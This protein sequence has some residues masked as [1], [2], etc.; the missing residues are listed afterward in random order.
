MLYRA[1]IFTTILGI[2]FSACGSGSRQPAADTSALLATDSAHSNIHPAGSYQGTLPCADCPGIDYQISLYDDNHYRTLMVYRD[3]NN[4]RPVI[5]TGTWQMEQD[6]LVRIIL[7]G[8]HKQLFRFEDGR[9]YQLNE[10][11]QPITGALADNYILRPVKSIDRGRLQE[12]AAAGIDF[13]A[14]GTR[15]GWNLEIDH[16]KTIS[17]HITNGDSLR[18]PMPRA[19]PNTDTLKVYTAKTET[20]E[21]ILTI[22]NAACMDDASGFMHPYSVEVQ[23]KDSTYRGCGEYL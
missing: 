6:T 16:Q 1:L 14:A 21:F 3:R 8:K 4:N 22:R 12:K 15:P 23:M 5:D 19:R 11:G 18:V 7:G 13:L 2:L 10:H 9:L 20:A 17:F